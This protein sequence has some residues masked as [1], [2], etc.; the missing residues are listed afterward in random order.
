MFVRVRS[1]CCEGRR[2][3]EGGAVPSL[4][5]AALGKNKRRPSLLRERSGRR[6]P[7]HRATEQVTILRGWLVLPVRYAHTH[8]GALSE[9]CKWYTRSTTSPPR[10]T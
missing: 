3:S 7:A 9:P 8:T 4:N 10:P 5:R 6:R 1:A 2:P